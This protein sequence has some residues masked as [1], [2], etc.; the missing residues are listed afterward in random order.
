MLA[1]KAI[2]TRKAKKATMP[3]NAMIMFLHWQLATHSGNDMENV[4]KKG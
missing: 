1:I 4:K 3:G 2:L